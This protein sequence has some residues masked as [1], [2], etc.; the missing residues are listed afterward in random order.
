MHNTC[1][2]MCMCMYARACVCTLAWCRRFCMAASSTGKAVRDPGH[3]RSD[4]L[5]CCSLE[6]VYMYAHTRN[7]I[8]IYATH[9][10]ICAHTYA[11]ALQY[12]RAQAH[13]GSGACGMQSTANAGRTSTNCRASCSI[14]RTSTFSSKS[15]DT[16]TT[17]E[18]NRD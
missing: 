6:S 1:L 4:D 7:C 12:M 2:C 5:T 18:N 17:N 11:I 8:T 3:F 13:L 10:S 16:G 15:A 14:V 9:P